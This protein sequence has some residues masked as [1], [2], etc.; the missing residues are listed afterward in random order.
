MNGEERAP[1]QHATRE[2]PEGWVP[3]FM[4]NLPECGWC[5]TRGEC[6]CSL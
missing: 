1:I 2:L 5:A 4:R 6:D 3:D